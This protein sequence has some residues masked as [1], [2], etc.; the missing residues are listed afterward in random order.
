MKPKPKVSI[1]VPIY[2]MEP[3]LAR[4][5]D[6]LLGQSLKELEIIAVDDGSTDASAAIAASRAESD[7][8]LQLIS[9]PN[10]GVAAARN[11][12]LAHCSGSYIGFADPDDWADSVMYEAMYG[13]AVKNDADIVMCAYVREF[14]SHSKAKAF[15]LDHKTFLRG[16]QLQHEVTRRLIGP[17]G[18]ETS[19]PEHL[20]AWGTVWNKLYRSSLIQREGIAFTSLREIGSNEDSLF[21][22]AAFRR[23]NRFLFLDRCYYHYW[24]VNAGSITTGYREELPEKFRRQY[25]LLETEAAA[26]PRSVP[27]REAL[28]NRIA[29]NVLGLGLN[30]I[31]RK[32][33]AN[34]L[35]KIRELKE[36]LSAP[37]TAEALRAFDSS[38]S[39]AVW[40][41][42]FAIARRRLA[43]PLLLL[44]YG[45]EFM[46]TRPKRKGRRHGDNPNSASGHLDESRGTGNDAY[47]LLPPAGKE[48][49]SI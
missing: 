48:R 11:L 28:Q 41:L 9:S 7:N 38:H 2:N 3:Y 49:H 18:A 47:E 27:F 42:F 29:M 16:E 46:R 23:A 33:P 20:D 22:V 40:R 4:C 37:A 36:I 14:G 13:E 15:P 1:V 26:L 30:I 5:L 45:A 34:S 44:L 8:R 25:A 21:N 24:R 35:G 39:A 19:S 32:N 6:S 17:I 43:A 12:G 10:A 31:S